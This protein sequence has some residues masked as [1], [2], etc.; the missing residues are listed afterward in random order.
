M[1][2][3]RNIMLALML[4]LSLSFAA[5]AKKQTVLSLSKGEMPDDV[6]NCEVTLSEDNVEKAGDFAM[7]LKFTKKG[8]WAG[9]DKPKKGGWDKFKAVH[10]NIFNPSDKQVDTLSFMIK[11]AKLTNTPENRK[12]WPITLK[13]GKNEVVIDLTGQI[14]NDGKTPLDLTRLL[15]WALWS[16]SEEPEMAVY[17]Q[18]IWLE[19]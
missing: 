10:I 13:P 8:G 2:V 15:R 12:D 1:A 14:C 11:G 7:L 5:Q 19:D 16:G 4:V 9:V 3:K 18:K 6:S 17:I